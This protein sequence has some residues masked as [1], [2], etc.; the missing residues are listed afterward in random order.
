MEYVLLAFYFPFC[1]DFVLV[2]FWKVHL[3]RYDKLLLSFGELN[4]ILLKVNNYVCTR[5]FS[6]HFMKQKVSNFP[7]ILT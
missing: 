7:L 1:S 2:L 3:Y 6:N 4:F 5:M